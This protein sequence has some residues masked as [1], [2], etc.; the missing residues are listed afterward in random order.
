M[1]L[2]NYHY[3]LS[4]SAE[5]DD[6]KSDGIKTELVDKFK[7]IFPTYPM[8]I[9]TLIALVL[10]ILILWFLLYKPIKKAI[11]ERQDYIQKN[12]DEAK[13]SNQLSQEKLKEANKRLAEAYVESDELVKNAKLHGEKIISD[14]TDKARIESKRII[15]RAQSEIETERIKM[16]Q[17]SK[18]NIANAAIEISKK[19]IGNE[20]SKKTQDEIINAYLNDES[21]K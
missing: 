3:A 20:I 21:N 15:E 1:I 12:I 19:I 8:I 17:E 9:A 4:Y 6:V 18:N 13:E 5:A 14:Y 10:V 16:A 7:T 2:T 11:K